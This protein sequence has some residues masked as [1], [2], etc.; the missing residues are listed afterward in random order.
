M[1]IL[2]F[3]KEALETEKR[4]ALLPVNVKTYCRL[5]A[6]VLVESGLGLTLGVADEEYVEAGPEIFTDREP[7]LAQADAVLSVR[8]IAFEDFDLCPKHSLSVSFFDPFNRTEHLKQVLNSQR[9]AISM[10]MI[11]RT[12]RCQKMD[13]L[14]SQAS[15]AGYVMVLKAMNQLNK[16]L[17]MM[18][19]PAGT[20][21]PAKIF[22]I[23][24]GV[25]G[26]QAIATAK[27]M[28]ASVLAYDT[29]AEVA[30]QVQSL[31]AKFLKI[32]LGETKSSD[33]GYASALTEEQMSLQ[34]KA[35][36]E[37]IADSDIVITTAQLFGRKPPLLI[38]N[39]VLKKM[40][41]G[42]VVVDMAAEDGGNV[43]A[44]VAGETIDFNG[45]KIVGTG[46]WA[47]EVSLDASQ[48]YANN[49]Q[50]LISDMWDEE[51]K[52]LHIDDSDEVLRSALITHKGELVNAII[53]ATHEKETA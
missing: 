20:L 48:M 12:S 23:G 39:D 50:A 24:A 31:G 27:R 1:S 42:S 17:P 15:L 21:K 30:E 53:K 49:L 7:A 51:R 5:G 35:Q 45:I 41:P 28:G 26:L 13:A 36:E 34:Q 44:S 11:P 8:S 2:V 29:R 38:T 19:T 47:S 52:A 32:D 46:N 6:K 22:V 37:C 10:E 43:E 3:P 18:M 40:R 4:I 9:S 16:T 14:S 25:A 33:Q